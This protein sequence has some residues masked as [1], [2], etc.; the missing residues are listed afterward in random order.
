MSSSTVTRYEPAE[1]VVLAQPLPADA[2]EVLVE[3]TAQRVVELIGAQLIELAQARAEAEAKPVS[4]SVIAKRFDLSPDWV[5][6]HWEQL[7]GFMLG[8]G[9]RARRRF[10]PAVVRERLPEVYRAA[11]PTPKP[12]PRPTPRRRRINPAADRTPA[13]A[14]LLRIGP[15]AA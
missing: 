2:L 6:A 9:P 15:K 7:G 5:R 12:E 10:W 13:G 8:D 3:A 11:P 1:D 14:P 4:T